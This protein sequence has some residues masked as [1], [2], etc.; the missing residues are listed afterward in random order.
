MG[1]RGVQLI[2]ISSHSRALQA[3]DQLPPM[4][5]AAA[6]CLSARQC[7]CQALITDPCRA[8]QVLAILVTA[9]GAALMTHG[10]F[11]YWSFFVGGVAV[12]MGTIVLEGVSMSLTSK[13]RPQQPP[14]MSQAQ[15][16]E[17]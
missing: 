14:E 6:G 15:Q 5:H 16:T 9:G 12:Y 1:C 2:T 10:A 4:H 3:F 7:L 17:A 8:G 13:V 11:P